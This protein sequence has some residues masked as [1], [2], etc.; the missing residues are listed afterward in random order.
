MFM[1]YPEPSVADEVKEVML[2]TP[3]QVLLTSSP[4]KE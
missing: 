1:V 2:V 3:G 4:L